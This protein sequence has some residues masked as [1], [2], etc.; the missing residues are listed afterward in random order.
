MKRPKH[1]LVATDFSECGKRA[2]A[3]AVALARRWDAGLH[4]LHVVETPM[5][6]FEPLAVAL[7]DGLAAELQET[8]TAG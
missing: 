4:W 6:L 7:P 1:I 5:P 3:T 8:A 2:E